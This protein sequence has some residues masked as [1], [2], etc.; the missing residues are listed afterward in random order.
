MRRYQNKQ[1]CFHKEFG[2]SLVEL[3]IVTAIIGIVL[4][5]FSNQSGSLRHVQKIK[6]SQSSLQKIKQEILNYGRVHKYLPCPDSDNDGFENR[7][8]SACSASVGTVPYLDLGLQKQET[9]DNW[10][11][12]FRYAVNTDSTNGGL[13]CDKRSSASIFCNQGANV[14]PWFTLTDTPPTS[15]D[16]GNGNYYVCN[17]STP[18]C[19]ATTVANNA[20]VSLN[21]ATVVLVAYNQDGDAALNDC[22]NQNT[23]SKENC[24]VDIYYHQAAGSN[25]DNQFFDDSILAISGY[26]IKSHILS[27]MVTWDS[28]ASSN[29]SSGLTPTYEDFD[30]TADDTVPVSNSPDTPDVIL[31]NRNVDTDLNLGGGD[32]YLAI[33]NDVKAGA[34]IDTGQGDDRLYIVGQ[35]QANIDLGR[36]DDTFVLGTDLRENLNADRGNDKVWIQGNVL[37]GS[38]LDM[39]QDDDVLWIGTSGN[40]ST[41]QID[42]DI[43]GGS[44]YDIL[45]LENTSKTEWESSSS[46]QNHV[47]NFELVIFEADESGA[48][49]YVTL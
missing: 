15:T 40:D 18:S 31:V 33:G 46:L 10:N 35:A 6:E 8:G 22:A 7:S 4:I 44:G 29:S 12:A 24:D 25:D 17:Q 47:D 16:R 30:I 37:S 48:R 13:I 34:E 1:A 21:T 43:N 19:N 20:N 5:G 42:D 41:G 2:F 23:A 26:E 11:N 32:D 3:M 27:Q 39:D 9:L 49:E 28:F 14:T 38:N 45:V 36:G